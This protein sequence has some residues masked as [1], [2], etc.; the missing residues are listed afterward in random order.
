MKGRGSE[1]AP[2][3]DLCLDDGM[4]HIFVAGP[5]VGEGIA[6]ALPGTG[7]LLVDGCEVRGRSILLE[8]VQRF[9]RTDD[10]LELLVLSHPH[11]DHARGL[12]KSIE[13]LEP[14]AIML[15]GK[16]PLGPHIL[17]CARSWLT[18]L[19][20][21]HTAEELRR[22]G[23]FSALKAVEAW[24]SRHPGGLVCGLDGVTRQ[25]GRVR[26]HTRAP[27]AGAHLNRVLDEFVSGRR[28]FVN[29]A[30]LV[31]ELEY[32][33]ARIVLGGDLPRNRHGIAPVPTGWDHVM[34]DH[35][36]LGGHSM[37][38]IPHHGSEASFED[39]LMSPA[40][41]DT[42][43]S[44]VLTPFDSS[45]LPRAFDATGIPRL[46]GRNH[47]LNLTRLMASCVLRDPTLT[48]VP[49]ADLLD[50]RTTQAMGDPFADAAE[51]T[52][53]RGDVD[54]MQPVWAFAFDDSGALCGQWRGGAALQIIA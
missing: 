35:P 21:T 33:K 3:E 20:H 12:A 53:P 2:I 5:G 30:S 11:E 37:L 52:R 31:L 45:R 29:E 46:I 15:T 42:T 19:E 18:G 23:V 32:G 6:V 47:T 10:A 48:S 34:A 49:L 14:R 36:H 44:W 28:T 43:R 25:W 51:D 41:P 8:L 9:R 16:D 13:A 50:R 27:T 38:K 26:L 4:I 22:R 1:I 40:S 24:E 39:R 17:A 7:W 54:P